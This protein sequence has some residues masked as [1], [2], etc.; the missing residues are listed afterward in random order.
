MAVRVTRL[1]LCMYQVSKRE[2][3]IVMSGDLV[4]VIVAC[5]AKL[6][7]VIDNKTCCCCHNPVLYYG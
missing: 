7:V 6:H 2:E 1:T 5:N 4:D 3:K